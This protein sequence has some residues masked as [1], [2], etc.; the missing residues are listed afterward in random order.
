M[1]K[2]RF[3]AR[4]L[5]VIEMEQSG[6]VNYE[7]AEPRSSNL[8]Y[9]NVFRGCSRQQSLFDAQLVPYLPAFSAPRIIIPHGRL[10]APNCIMSTS[11][12]FYCAAAQTFERELLGG[13]GELLAKDS[14]FD[15]MRTFRLCIVAIQFYHLLI[16]NISIQVYSVRPTAGTSCRLVAET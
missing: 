9:S 6:I 10:P 5:A 11:P 3:L 7:C 13:G 14:S 16:T 15:A 8:R 12:H 4:R 1:G 2:Q